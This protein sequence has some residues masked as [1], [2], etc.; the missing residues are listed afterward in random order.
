MAFAPNLFSQSSAQSS[1]TNVHNF[2]LPLVSQ[3]DD[4][5]FTDT[6]PLDLPFQDEPLPI[7]PPASSVT[8]LHHEV[9]SLLTGVVYTTSFKTVSSN[10]WVY[11]QPILI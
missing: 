8:T 4:L 6:L 11:N 5:P 2:P 7:A 1:I 3:D 9:P 10:F